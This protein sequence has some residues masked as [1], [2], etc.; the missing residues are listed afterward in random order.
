MNYVLTFL[1]LAFLLIAIPLGLMLAPL[2]VGVFL[3]GLVSRRG[4]HYFQGSPPARS[5]AA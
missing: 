1:G 5:G 4:H 2:A 3:L